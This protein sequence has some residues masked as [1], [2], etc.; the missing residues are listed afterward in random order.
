MARTQKTSKHRYRKA[1]QRRT[2]KEPLRPLSAEQEYTFILLDLIS[3]D[4]ILSS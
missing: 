2:R 4:L 3:D 1:E